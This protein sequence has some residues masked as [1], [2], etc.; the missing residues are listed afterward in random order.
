MFNKK[1]TY[2]IEH[3]ALRSEALTEPPEEEDGEKENED[4]VVQFRGDAV[5]WRILL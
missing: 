2:S 3:P 4:T 5:Y 1:P